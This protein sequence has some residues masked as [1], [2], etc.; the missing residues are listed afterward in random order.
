MRR[1][2]GRKLIDYKHFVSLI[3]FTAKA[4]QEKVLPKAKAFR[5]F[6]GGEQNPY[7]THSLWCATMILLDTQLPEKIRVPGA[8]ALLLHDV[9]EDTSASL[10]KNISD[11]VRYFVKEMTY[12][13]GFNEEK[14]AV[15]LKPPIIQLLKLYDKT[16]TL[17]DGDI[18]KARYGEWT[19]FM[20]K[21]INAVEPNYGT[22]NIILLARELIKKYQNMS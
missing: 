3:G 8:E 16:A 9:I 19:E 12:A 4:H 20:Q 21:I 17:Y 22:L 11:E 14:T 1:F 6:S 10:P 15:L 18:K 13:G 5:T 7:F 2:F